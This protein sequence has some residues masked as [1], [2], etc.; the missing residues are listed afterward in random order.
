MTCPAGSMLIPTSGRCRVG[1]L[2]DAHLAELRPVT[3]IHGH[4]HDLRGR[5]KV[6]RDAALSLAKVVGLHVRRAGIAINESF[7]KEVLVRVVQAAGPV[8]PK[9]PR[10]GACCLCE[11]AG[12]LRPCISVFRSHPELCGDEGHAS[13]R[14]LGDVRNLIT[15]AAHVGLAAESGDEEYVPLADPR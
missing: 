4:A 11:A 14:C 8:E 12:D 3:L 6:R 15:S 1:P 10:L 7:D 2:S 9:A 5:Y 13:P